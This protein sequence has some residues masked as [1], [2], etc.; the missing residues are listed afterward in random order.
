[1]FQ[2]VAG[3]LAPKSGGLVPRMCLWT[4][5]GAVACSSNASNQVTAPT[6]VGMTNNTPAYYSDGNLTLYEVQIPVPLP[7][8]RPTAAEREA[9]GG[10]PSGTP[11]PH[12]PFLLASDESVEVHYVLSNIDSAQHAVW[13]LIDPWNEFVRYRP[14]VTIVD[15]ETTVPNE[16]FEP[17]GPGFL[18]GPMSR[19]EGTI[20][21]DDMQEL[22]IRL[23]ATENFLMSP[24]T[25]AAEDS[26]ASG[27]DNSLDPTEIAN[28]IFDQQNFSTTGDPLFAPYI[29]RI[30]AG[31]TGFD[32][33]LRTL[34]PANIAVEITI[35]VQD[36]NG[37]RF[38]AQ[39]T[40]AP[41]LGL[42][43]ATLAPPGARY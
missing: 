10:P 17:G 12:M 22:A 37:N 29:P 16:S 41:L 43:P 32:L 14:G 4:A 3:G 8:R 24:Q 1:M 26:D 30:I 2:A 28:H 19:I 23:A 33:G 27:G 39:D 5:L 18:M 15:D 9:L 35:D 31:I 11:Y 34:E 25:L 20:T 38:V 36:L 40:T 6:A 7:V 21:T 13:L 42:P